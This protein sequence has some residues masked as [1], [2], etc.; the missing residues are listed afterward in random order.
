MQD[1][2][3][4]QF[5]P[6][7]IKGPTTIGDSVLN[8]LCRHTKLHSKPKH[9]NMRALDTS[10]NQTPCSGPYEPRT[11]KGNYVTTDSKV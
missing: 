1:I 3:P 7:P 9:D 10:Q 5:P 6:W 8:E 11:K 2:K 4:N